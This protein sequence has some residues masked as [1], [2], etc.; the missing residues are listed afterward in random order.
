MQ[1]VL[2]IPSEGV[3]F[4][5]V[6]GYLHKLRAYIETSD[7]AGYDPY[8]ALNSPFIKKVSSQSKW[9]KIAC[10]QFLRRSPVNLRALLATKKGHNPKAIGL[11]L[12]GYTR[13]YAMREKSGYRQKI[14]YLLDL[15][16]ELRSEGWSGNCW[17]YNFDWQNR[18]MWTPKYTP[19]IVNSAFIGHALLDTYFLGGV[20]RALDMAVGIKDFICH[21]LV[22]YE[23]KD[24]L[25]FSYTPLDDNYVH[26]ANLL[27]ASLLIRLYRICEDRTLEK[28]ALSSL[29]Y[30]LH[31][32]RANGAWYYGQM[33]LMRYV[34]SFHTAFNLQALQYFI[35]EG[36]DTFCQ[37]H[38]NL[39]LRYYVEN[40]FLSDGTAKYYD[41]K[42]FPIDIHSLC[43]AIVLLSDP[44][45]VGQSELLKCVLE[46]MLKYMWSPKGYFYYRKGRF[47]TNKICYMRWSQAWA[48]HALTSYLYNKTL[49][50]VA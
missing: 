14:E 18:T 2:S 38:Y 29:R 28:L 35:R 41:N 9:L 3:G 16:E 36:Y 33:N 1:E 13:L 50:G 48:F 26:N 30:G 20:D 10:T 45:V 15:L 6:E 11:F 43:Q 47:H 40:F 44:L 27:G 49:E 12:W 25:C 8:D 34:D 24:R 22:R 23:E 42:I 4:R 5:I 37:T 7:Y 17:G 19:T 46:W 39:G 32:Q 31:Y 21:D